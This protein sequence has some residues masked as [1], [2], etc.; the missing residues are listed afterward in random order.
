MK[1]GLRTV[2]TAISAALAMIIAEKLGLLYAP[3]A[4]IISVLS[5]TSTKKT[6]VMTGIYRLLS[7]ALATILAYICFTFL[8]FT[9]IAFGIFLLLF[10]P[11]AVYFQLS[12]GIVV[13]S[14]LVTHYLV[15]KNLS[16]AIIGNEFLLMSIGVGLALS[17]NSYMPD[18]EKR[19]REDQ[20]VIEIMFRK[21]LREMALHLNNAAGERNLVMHCADLKTFIRTGETW[22]KNHAEN[23]LLSTNTYY[24]EYFAMRKMQSNILKN[25]LELLEDITVDA[26]QVRYIQQ[27]LE[28]TAETFAENND[29]QEIMNRIK[30]VYE[31][32]RTKPLPQTRSE[33][34]N[35]ARLF[36]FLQLFQSFIQ[37][38]AD[39]AKLQLDK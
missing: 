10:I 6:S 3:S 22:A 13:S 38:K 12:D 35:R 33:F 32:Y 5:V 25:M 39:F 31:T 11:A 36:Q 26:Q 30:T 37:V 21:I 7:L 24:L 23:Q 9:A 8:G 17:A 16:W 4:G 29:G 20:E 34:E 15:E 1:I 19:L 2:K 27:L 18:T 28:Y 14:V